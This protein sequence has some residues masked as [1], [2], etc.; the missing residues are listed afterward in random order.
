MTSY[1]ALKLSKQGLKR[2]LIGDLWFTQEHIKD[3]HKE[4]D[5][6][7]PGE[8]VKVFSQESYFLGIGYF[9]PKVH[10]C[11]KLITKEDMIIDEKFFCSKFTKLYKFKKI[12]YPEDEALRLVF[13]E[14]DFLPGL[15]IDLYKD[16]AVVQTYTLG[17][18]KLLSFIIQGLKN[19]FSFLRA[20]VIKNNFSKRKEEGLPLYVRTEG[21]VEE[22]LSIKMGGLKWLIPVIKG[23]KTGSFL[24]QRENRIFI[25][26]I[27]KD[28]QVIDAFSYIGGFAFYALLGGAKKVFLID[29]SSF[30]LDVAKE[31]AQINGFMEKVVLIEE[32]VHQF[33][34]NFS[35]QGILILDPPAYIKS[36]KDV[37]KGEKKYQSLYHL[38]IKALEK[39]FLLA[40]SCSYFLEEE[41][42]KTYLIDSARRLNKEI[43]IVYRG[44][45]ALDHPVHPVIKETC[46][47]KSIGVYLE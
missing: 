33:L 11:L 29:T 42:L 41:K 5:R 25:K 38:G 18:E 30:A 36:R 34:K 9:N 13:A 26:K 15:I 32:D 6:I 28:A 45:Q 1:P 44:F 22:L 16:V 43:R 39:G 27:A 12:F 31:I 2:Y 8:L 4:K 24:D 19:A 47:L 46:Y 20:I 21:D 40:C 23:Q 35:S 3:F 14:G 7:S 37:K 10:Y 17:M